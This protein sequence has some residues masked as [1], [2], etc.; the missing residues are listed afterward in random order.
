M[1]RSLDHWRMAEL[2][3]EREIAA[4][5]A[6][7]ETDR[8]FRRLW[9][10][11]MIA[12]G[13][14]IYSIAINSPNPNQEDKSFLKETK[15]E[16]SECFMDKQIVVLIKF[17]FGKV[18]KVLIASCSAVPGITTRS[19]DQVEFISAAK[20]F[21][22]YVGTVPEIYRAALQMTTTLTEAPLM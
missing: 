2:G 13:Q 12:S 9:D 14:S 20:G 21:R 10:L 7:A 6:Q 4:R 15:R 5:D 18:R 19:G 22:N 11:L 17:F 3:K 16:V 8:E 1:V